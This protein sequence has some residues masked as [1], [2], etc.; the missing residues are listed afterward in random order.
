[1]SY[2][3]EHVGRD[4]SRP[5]REGGSD[6]IVVLCEDENLVSNVSRHSEAYRI[7]MCMWSPSPRL[8]MKATDG[9]LVT[10]HYP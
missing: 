5:A 2:I 9:L 10:S 8:A 6:S 3:I 7:Q 4:G 1:M